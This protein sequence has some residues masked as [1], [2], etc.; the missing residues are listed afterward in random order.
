MGYKSNSKVLSNE[1]QGQQL[2][3]DGGFQLQELR[4]D[5]SDHMAGDYISYHIMVRNDSKT[6]IIA[7]LPNLIHHYLYL[8][9]K[10]KIFFF[11]FFIFGKGLHHNF[12]K[13]N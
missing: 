3:I 12:L 9:K 11:D 6:N 5:Q 2:L 10:R 4:E 7:V 8:L 1:N 13:K